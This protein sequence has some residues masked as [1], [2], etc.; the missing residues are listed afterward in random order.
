MIANI[1]KGGKYE[2]V[3]NI[4]HTDVS[5][6]SLAARGAEICRFFKRQLT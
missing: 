4:L 6:K 5:T 2:T 1:L 3:F